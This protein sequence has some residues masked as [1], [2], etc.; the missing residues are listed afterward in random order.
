VR[1]PAFDFP[2]RLGPLGDQGLELIA[3]AGE[4]VAGGDD[5]S[6]IGRGTEPVQDSPAGC[7]G[8]G[9]PRI[10]TARVSIQRQA[11]S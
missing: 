9:T 8:S 6:D 4:D 2:Q 3:A 1:E 5:F 11:P 10:G 7:S